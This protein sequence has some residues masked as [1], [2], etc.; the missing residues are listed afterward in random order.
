LSAPLSDQPLANLPRFG[1]S[2]SAHSIHALQKGARA[3]RGVRDM[4]HPW[5]EGGGFGRVGRYPYGTIDPAAVGGET[6]MGH[7]HA[8]LNARLG[9]PTCVAT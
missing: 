6:W 3:V 7:L 8:Y 5:A 9:V 2:M 1:G 4:R